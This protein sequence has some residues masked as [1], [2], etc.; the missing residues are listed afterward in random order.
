M[1][2]RGR[3]WRRRG[4]VVLGCVLLAVCVLIVPG[5]FGRTLHGTIVVI[6][7]GDGKGTVIGQASGQTV[8]NCGDSCTASVLDPTDPSYTPVT[9]RA[10]PAPG[11][12]LRG[13]FGCAANGDTCV[14][15]I[16]RLVRSEVTAWFDVS[17]ASEYP[18]TVS[19]AGQ[20]RVVSD[21]AGID[22]GA[23][24]A[25]N[26]ARDS[27]VTLTAE[28]V[29]GWT[30]AGWSGACTGLGACV[31]K[32]DQ[33]KSVM[34]TFSPPTLPLSLS[35]AGG[36]TVTS[37]PVGIDCSS[38]CVGNL[39]GGGDVTLTAT[40]T[41]G[42]SFSG[43]GGACSG[44]ALTCTVTL[45]TA[46]AVTAS[47]ADA[48]GV[49]LATVVTGSGTV[50]SSPSGLECEPTCGAV[51]PSG[52]SVTL[53]AKPA[54][55]WRLESWGLACRGAKPTCL[56]PLLTGRGVTAEFVQQSETEPLAV[57]KTGAGRI[58]SIPKGIDCGA[59]CTAQLATGSTVALTATPAKGSL[60][61]RWTG[62]CTGAKSSC[63]VTMTRARTVAAE[64]AT[65]SDR[66]APRVRALAS[67]GQRQDGVRLRYKVVEAGRSSR[68]VAV[69]YSGRKKLA[70]ISGRMD[71]L[72]PD[73]LFD[74]LVWRPRSSIRPG[75]YRF[76]VTSLDPSGNVSRPSCAAVRLR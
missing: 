67:D 44:A 14:I 16:K 43:W 3:S 6:R 39:P 48:E 63:R 59:V 18:L 33:A 2:R 58:T 51:F 75:V 15:E 32:I 10:I 8:I 49:P 40:A 13:W 20:G 5:A 56:V 74:F 11:S 31:I 53:T 68:E 41:P 38:A 52:S 26:F 35:I 17:T 47:F 22:C 37:D 42:G 54:A 34:A 29:S 61:V 21:P 9:L 24:C 64:F 7:T 55:G 25:A 76:C 57:T 73:V 60:F 70:T 46:R 1:G 28:P 62:D 27:S 36:G 30:F 19:L 50:T 66:I 71:A 65:S 23:G 69:V 45:A 4:S 72:D 12:V